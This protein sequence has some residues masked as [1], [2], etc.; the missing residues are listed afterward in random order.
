MPCT[1]KMYLWYVEV[2]IEQLILNLTHLWRLS[3]LLHLAERNFSGNHCVAEILTKGFRGKLVTFPEVKR[4]SS[5]ESLLSMVHLRFCL[6]T[7]LTTHLCYI[8]SAY[9]ITV[10]L[11]KR[12]VSDRW[13][14]CLN[15][16]NC[17]GRKQECCVSANPIRAVKSFQSSTPMQTTHNNYLLYKLH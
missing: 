13:A 5:K 10:L 12:T 14:T 8:P 9:K 3:D 2:H 17:W 6:F 7:R 11:D 4:G 15:R 1:S 16:P